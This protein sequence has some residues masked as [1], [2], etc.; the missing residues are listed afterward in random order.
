MDVNALPIK[1]SV[2]LGLSLLL[3]SLFVEVLTSLV[4]HKTSKTTDFNVWSNSLTTDI[5]FLKS[6]SIVTPFDSLSDTVTVIESVF[7]NVKSS[8]S[9]ISSKTSFHLYSLGKLYKLLTT[10]RNI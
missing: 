4:S 6:G 2:T 7:F 3:Q 1:T 8:G 5:G 10:A 9:N